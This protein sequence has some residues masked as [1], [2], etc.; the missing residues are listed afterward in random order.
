M[1]YN[2]ENDIKKQI[3]GAKTIYTF[4]SLT[5]YKYEI[6]STFFSVSIKGVINLI[7]KK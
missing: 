5:T 3:Q 7:N 4:S 1:L 2:Y 6:K